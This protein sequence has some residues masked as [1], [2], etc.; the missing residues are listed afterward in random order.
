MLTKIKEDIID[1]NRKGVVADVQKALDDGI[2][3][4]EVLNEAMIPAMAEVG[5]LFEAVALAK[6]LAA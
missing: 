2:K 4:E 5:T 6:R 1:G 3:A